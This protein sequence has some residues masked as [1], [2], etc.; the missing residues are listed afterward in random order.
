[1]TKANTIA[2]LTCPVPQSWI[3]INALVRRF[4]AKNIHVLA[5][6][7]VSRGELIARR[8]R[9][10]GVVT[11]LGQIAFVMLQKLIDRR[12]RPRVAE[13][14]A[15]MALETEPD[16][17][18][19]VY[20]I[21]S[22]NSMAAR[23]A[24]AMVQPDVVVVIGTRIIGRATLA[25]LRVPVINAHMG[26]NPLYRGQAGGYWALAK[27]DPEH[28]GVTI[29]LVDHGVDTGGILYQER[30][31]ATPRDSFGTYFYIQSGA[32]RA[33]LLRAVEDALAGTLKVQASGGLAS[34]EHFHP[35]IWGYIWTGLRRGVW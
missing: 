12:Q 15:E 9:K 33:P 4:G 5:E 26:W 31:G 1:M 32:A 19:P 17:G 10:R 34:A 35:T 11:V 3:L 29:H 28:A 2:V 30:F 8:M 22:V 6:D 14:T 24:L 21:G 27:G 25:A 7:R 23:T 13:I 16:P 20:P 18:C